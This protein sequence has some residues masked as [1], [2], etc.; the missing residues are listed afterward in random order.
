ML[1]VFVVRRFDD[2]ARKPGRVEYQCRW[3]GVTSYADSASV[4]FSAQEY[5]DCQ[6]AEGGGVASCLRHGDYRSVHWKSGKTIG[7]CRRCFEDE[8][9]RRRREN[10]LCKICG[11]RFGFLA[12]LSGQVTHSSHSGSDRL[13]YV[14]GRTDVGGSVRIG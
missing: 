9:R 5:G 1:D 3:C 12:R 10:G 2:H 8:L 13:H 6:G 4:L 14:E 11:L 7:E